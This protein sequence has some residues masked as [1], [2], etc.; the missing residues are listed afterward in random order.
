MLGNDR[1]ERTLGQ[2]AVADFA[3]AGAAGAAGFADAERREVVMEKE[4]LRGFAATVGV[5]VLRFFDR[6]ERDERERLGFAALENRGT[7]RARQNADFAGD[8]PQILVAAAIHALLLVEHADA[9]RFLLDVIERLGD[10]ELVGLREF[11]QHRGLHFFLERVRPLC[12]ARLC[13]GV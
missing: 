11:L 12:C 2:R 4:A 1:L 9:E 10:R 8:L 13:F 7:M 6:R 3:T 5:D